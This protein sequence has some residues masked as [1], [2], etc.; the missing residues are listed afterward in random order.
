MKDARTPRSN[1]TDGR[2]C[3]DVIVIGDGIIGLSV[4]LAVAR[5][6]G[7]TCIIGLPARGAAS[8]ASAGLLAPS[9]GPGDAVVRGVMTTARDRYP[10]FVH[11][12]AERTGID[13]PLNRDGI[14]EIV[15]SPMGGPELAAVPPPLGASP[16]TVVS[17][18]QLR[19]L[20]PSLSGARGALL[21]PLDGFVDN[22][23]L[24]AAM[25]EAARCEWAVDIVDGRAARV[26]CASAPC[27]VVTEDGRR[28]VGGAIVLAAGAWSPLVDG[29]P[30]PLHIEPV[31]GQMLSLQGG[32]LSRAIAAPD[33]Y[34][35]PR[36]GT[37]LVGSTLERVGFDSTTTASSLQHL[38]DAAI[39]LLPELAS[40]LVVDSW[41]GLRP[42]TP[43][44][45]PILGRD[46]A[47]PSLIYACGH[48]K[49]GILL[50]PLTGEC[51]AALV[52]G[53]QP[54]I[55]LRPFAVDRFD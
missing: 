12:L 16:A 2:D 50:A 23:R 21:H 29:L 48:G 52:A 40:A 46:P 31:R 22:V 9:M 17:S 34:L 6:G 8:H 32:A 11:W 18:Q 24:L 20:E 44:A 28:H 33:A 27:S 39:A 42:M 7:T 1:G 53:D 14:V 5:A 55:D 13:V 36:A 47:F 35:V 51:V 37:T 3:P 41:A 49:N 45:V 25:R 38:R 4:A 15:P 10:D 30:R 54:P 43:D 26:D 19:S